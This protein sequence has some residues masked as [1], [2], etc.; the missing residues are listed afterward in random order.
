MPYPLIDLTVPTDRQDWD[1]FMIDAPMG[2]AQYWGLLCYITLV[3]YN[4]GFLDESLRMLW[5]KSYMNR[6]EYWQR[7]QANKPYLS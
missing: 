7:N 1:S 5:N 2:H 3:E 6:E 4:I